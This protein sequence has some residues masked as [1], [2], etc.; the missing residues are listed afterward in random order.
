MKW[1]SFLRLLKNEKRYDSGFSGT[2][3]CSKKLPKNLKKF[4]ER[5]SDKKVRLL[6]ASKNAVTNRQKSNGQMT[7][8]QNLKKDHSTI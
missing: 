1:K 2:L 8:G 3:F 6:S 5:L 7:I 4:S